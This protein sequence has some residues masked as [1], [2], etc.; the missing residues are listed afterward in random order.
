VFQRGES[1]DP[2]AFSAV[3]HNDQTF[4]A[5]LPVQMLTQGFLLGYRL[6][7]A[8]FDT[9]VQVPASSSDETKNQWADCMSDLLKD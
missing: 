9:V 3:V 8:G 6:S 5:E 1:E 2:N 7:N 4:M